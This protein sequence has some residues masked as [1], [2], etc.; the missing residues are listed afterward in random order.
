[1]ITTGFDKRVERVGFLFMCL[2]GVD[3]RSD[4]TDVWPS[5]VNVFFV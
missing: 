4:Y 3:I 1:M 2:V 5:I